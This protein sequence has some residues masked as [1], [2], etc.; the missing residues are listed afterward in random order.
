MAYHVMLGLLWAW[1]LRERWG[2]FNPK[3]IWTAVIGSVLPDV[4][5]IYY[6][7][8][9]G[10]NDSYTGQVIIYLKGREWRNLV[11][12]MATGHKHNT[13]LAYHNV[14]TVGFLIIISAAASFIDWEVGVVLFG[15]MVS[16]YLFDM[17]DDL[18]QLGAIN[19]NWRRWGAGRKKK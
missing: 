15:A 13:S 8:G 9:Y 19:P 2:E 4:E 5:H 17:A 6:F 14:Y 3:W 18:V 1:F 10:R 7:L 16:H 12:F 11:H